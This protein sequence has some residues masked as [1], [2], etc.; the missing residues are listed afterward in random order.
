MVGAGSGF[1]FGFYAT[2]PGK[3]RKKKDESS[4]LEPPHTH[5]RPVRP[6]HPAIS[7]TKIKLCFDNDEGLGKTGQ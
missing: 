1:C 4:A 5:T 2:V 7:M 6:M 3:E